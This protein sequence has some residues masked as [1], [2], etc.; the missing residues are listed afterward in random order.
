MSADYSRIILNAFP[1]LADAQAAAT[2]IS[3]PHVEIVAVQLLKAT[4]PVA[5]FVVPEGYRCG[6]CEQMV[7]A[8]DPE[9][10]GV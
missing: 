7:E 9:R 2:L 4:R 10:E 3:S 5:Y 6:A 8:W 1:T